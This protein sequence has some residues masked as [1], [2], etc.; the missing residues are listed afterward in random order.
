MYT[1]LSSIRHERAR[2]ERNR[3]ILESSLEDSYISDLMMDEKENT[4]SEG[5][6]VQELNKLIDNLPESDS[7]DEEVDRILSSEE[8]MTVDEIFGVNENTVDNL[9][10]SVFQ[11]KRHNFKQTF[12]ESKN[13][14]SSSKQSFSDPLKLTAAYN[15]SYL[16]GK[17]RS[18]FIG[19]Y[20][21]VPIKFTGKKFPDTVDPKIINNVVKAAD[22]ILKTIA[23]DI[24]DTYNTTLG[25]K[26]PKAWSTTKEFKKKKPDDVLKYLKIEYVLINCTGSKSD[27][28]EKLSSIFYIKHNGLDNGDGYV[29]KNKFNIKDKTWEKELSIPNYSN[30]NFS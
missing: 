16:S 17:D 12:T 9:Y 22:I 13:T 29:V 21:K 28:S 27:N 2:I 23:A 7:E 4:Y 8:N 14:A 11:R 30:T 20:K 10:E 26:S 19:V 3:I 15:L 24:V 6:S 18:N 5:C 1:G 25:K